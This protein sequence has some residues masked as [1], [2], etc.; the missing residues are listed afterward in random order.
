MNPAY[1]R[2]LNSVITRL[3]LAGAVFLTSHGVLTKEEADALVSP[4]VEVV[5]GLAVSGIMFAYAWIRARA[6]QVTINTA[7]AMPPSSLAQV[8]AKIATGTA[9]PADAP[10]TEVPKV[11]P[12]VA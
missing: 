3:I 9:A 4:T 12:K 11:E 1:Q 2:V 10:K 6:T 8:E 5:V 7:A